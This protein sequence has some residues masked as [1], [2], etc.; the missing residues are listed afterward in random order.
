MHTPAP[1]L[2]LTLL[3]T[4]ISAEEL[5]ASDVPTACSTICGPIVTLTNTCDINPDSESSS[6]GG[7]LRRR[8]LYLRDPKDDDGDDKGGNGKESP[9]D[10]SDEPIEAQC[11]C[12]NKSFN[13]QRVAALCAACLTQNGGETEDMNK[14][15]SQCT[16]ASTT[17]VPAATTAV[18][19]I[20]VLATKPAAT[21]VTAA[22]NIKTTT[23]TGSAASSTGTGSSSSSNSNSGKTSDSPATAR[24][25]TAAVVA[26]A[27]VMG[28]A[29]LM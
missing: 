7:K 21:D 20:T 25:G 18:A 5:K 26:A 9:D 12:T 15:M 16:F 29:S 22:T 2:L 19:G 14:I 28:F 24:R 27:L 1:L 6:A 3:T 8:F 13:V 17:Y 4:L 23:S 11:I 10:E